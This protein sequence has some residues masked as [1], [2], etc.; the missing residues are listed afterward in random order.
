MNASTPLGEWNTYDIRLVGREITTVLDGQTLY[1]RAVIAGLNGIAI[2]PFEGR[3]GP[4]ELQGDE[5][6]TDFRNIV[7]VP[8]TRRNRK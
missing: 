3:P 7:L 1:K 2:D 6:A 5:T 4:I 8:L